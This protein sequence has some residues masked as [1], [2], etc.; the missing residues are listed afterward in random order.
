MNYVRL[1]TATRNQITQESAIVF[2]TQSEW[3]NKTVDS[4]VNAQLSLAWGENYRDILETHAFSA[5][6]SQAVLHVGRLG[7]KSVPVVVAGVGKLNRPWHENLEAFRK[8]LGRALSALAGSAKATVQITLP[9]PSLFGI[10][11]AELVRQAVFVAHLALYSNKDFKGAA[12]PADAHKVWAP[13]IVIVDSQ[14]GD[15]ESCHQANII[16][17]AMNMTRRLSDA[18]ANHMTPIM[19]AERAEKIAHKHNLEMRWFDQ[20]HAEKIGMGCFVSVAKGSINPGQFVT[21]TYSCGDESAPT[22]AL[23]GKGVCFDTGGNSL[24][25][26]NSMTGMKYD[27]SGAAAVFAVMDILGSLKPAGV[28]VIGVAPLVENMPGWRASKQDDVVT[29][30]NGVTVEIENTDAEGRL[31]LADALTYVQ[32]EFKPEVIIDIATLTGACMYALG[33]FFSGMMTRDDALAEELVK[34]GRVVGDQVWRLPLTD[35]YKPAVKSVIADIGN[36]GVPV[37]KAGATTAALFLEHFI[38]DNRRWVHLDIAGTDSKIPDT[39]YYGKGAT[40]VG[41]RLLTEFVLN[42]K[43][44]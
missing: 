15:E 39:T 4:G 41:V 26:A 25:P 34:L 16:G 3:S 30:L 22:I 32:R 1:Q 12:T 40:G 29:A 35:D 36:S 33:H 9:Q 28:N 11:H 5:G 6:G 18:P 14:S 31:I 10:S 2:M 7:S 13:Q 19:M 23:V 24:K 38:E 37:Y 21:M 27:M 44:A 17:E 43:R 42:Y 20:D 8:S